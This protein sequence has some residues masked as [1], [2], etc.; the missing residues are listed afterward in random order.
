MYVRNIVKVI[1][2]CLK[3]FYSIHA[4]VGEPELDN[5]RGHK[6]L[7]LVRLSSS[8]TTV[9]FVWLRASRKLEVMSSSL[10]LLWMLETLL[11]NLSRYNI[12]KELIIRTPVFPVILD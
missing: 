1:I 7:E 11:S 9:T 4:H 8:S 6:R 12:F 5:I 10:P 2:L 3:L